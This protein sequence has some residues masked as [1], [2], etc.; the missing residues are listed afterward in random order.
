MRPVPQH[1]LKRMLAWR[2][3]NERLSLSCTEMKMCFVLWD[4]L[5]RI[6]RFIY[7]D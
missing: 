5:V 6:Q 3:F 2:Q 1:W 4:W 7:V